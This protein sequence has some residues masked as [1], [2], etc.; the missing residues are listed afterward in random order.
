MT[1]AANQSCLYGYLASGSSS[2]VGAPASSVFE[3]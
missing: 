1:A 2:I 3:T